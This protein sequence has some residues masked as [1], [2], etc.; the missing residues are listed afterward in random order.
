MGTNEDTLNFFEDLQQRLERAELS[1]EDD[2]LEKS[3]KLS[4]TDE[5]A[6][7]NARIEAMQK[8]QKFNEK[9][10]PKEE[11]SNANEKIVDELINRKINKLI[12]G[13]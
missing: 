2:G 7:T 11:L 8:G 5:G 9:D 12:N 6:R 1:F 4:Q 13:E 10:T 3:I